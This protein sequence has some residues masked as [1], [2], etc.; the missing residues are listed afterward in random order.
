MLSSLDS[1][2][3]SLSTDHLQPVF[4]LVDASHPLD[5]YIG[6]N[7][8]GRRL[9]LLVTPEEPPS[10][11]NMRAVQIRALRRDDGKWSL[12]L[13]LE[14]SSLTPMFS[15]LCEDLIKSSR[16]AGLA[17]G[18]SLN[19][20][21][22][23]LSKWRRLFERGLPDLLSEQQVRG[24]CG[25]LLF[26]RYLFSHLGIAET[27]KAWV[28]PQRADQDFQSPDA[29]WEVKT[30][31]P[32]AEVVSISSESQL[33]TITRPIHMAVL[34]LA[35]CAQGTADGFTLNTLVDEIRERLADD[36]DTGELFELSLHTAGY[37]P[38]PE[39]DETAL[40]ALPMQLFSVIPGFP[41]IT[42]D[43]LEGGICRVS[44]DIRLDACSSFLSETS[45]LTEPRP[46]K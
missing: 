19:F 1:R 14:S 30:I 42:G 43:T 16:N 31:R 18:K 11:R 21:L 26:M 24:L 8:E 35:D 29:A 44:Y 40:V 37:A 33:Q 2:W 34:P 7:P 38:R 27:V 4:Q 12:L 9:L 6:R 28:G 23:R 25:E 10:M 3:D 32:G 36:H 5:F 46:S 22:N 15:L 39:Y 17:T 13:T 45:H 41:R 20:V